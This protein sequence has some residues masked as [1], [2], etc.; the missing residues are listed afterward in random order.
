MTLNDI[1][2]YIFYRSIR[3]GD[4]ETFY[5]LSLDVEDYEEYI[6][7]DEE[8]QN[9]WDNVCEVYESLAM[10][11][12][13]LNT[14]PNNTDIRTL[15]FDIRNDSDIVDYIEQMQER[16]L[17]EIKRRTN[18]KL[19]EI[20]QLSY[21]NSFFED[22]IIDY[23]HSGMQARMQMTSELKQ[24][25]ALNFGHPLIIDLSY[26]KEMAL[27]HKSFFAI[28]YLY[29][30]IKMNRMSPNPFD[31]YLTNF[32]SIKDYHVIMQ[33]FNTEKDTNE[34]LEHFTPECYT[35][36]FPKEN[37]VILSPD[38]PNVLEYD[39]KDI[40]ILGSMMAI[41][42]APLTLKKAKKQ[43]IRHAKLPMEDNVGLNCPLNI[44]TMIPI[45]QDFRQT[46]DWFYSLRWIPPEFFENILKESPFSL[47]QEYA[48]LSH[49]KLH[50]LSFYSDNGTLRPHEYRQK[51]A[52][53]MSLLPEV[54]ADELNFSPKYKKKVFARRLVHVE[55]DRK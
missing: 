26:Y 29:S 36:L 31:I 2:M 52:G 28:A 18:Q 12:V 21:E 48:Y 34:N 55:I 9:H 32:G 3:D 44:D 39:P 17:D 33:V 10:K 11:G 19:A 5:T 16:R 50:P 54:G 42:G 41:D 8:L 45:L 51:Y 4:N 24:C 53:L 14:K 25:N 43:N 7:G 47:R 30:A 22:S 46:Q 1:P 13:Y 40:Y 27:R 38:S 23:G 20:Q 15:I 6:G 49:K 35:D 37:L